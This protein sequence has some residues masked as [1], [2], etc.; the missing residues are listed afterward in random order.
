MMNANFFLLEI[1]ATEIGNFTAMMVYNPTIQSKSLN[2]CKSNIVTV[3]SRLF[4]GGIVLNETFTMS[5]TL[6]CVCVCLPLS[7]NHRLS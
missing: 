4:G 6:M 1:V 5:M 2:S 7:S 3:F